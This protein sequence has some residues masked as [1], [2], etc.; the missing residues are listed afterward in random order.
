MVGNSCFETVFVKQNFRYKQTGLVEHRL[1]V[2]CCVINAVLADIVVYIG[3]ECIII[4]LLLTVPTMGYAILG[5]IMM[6]SH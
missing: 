6:L 4:I 5:C 3:Y 2:N 1:H